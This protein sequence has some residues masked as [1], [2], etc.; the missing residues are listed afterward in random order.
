MLQD[1]PE[2]L[3]EPEA[4]AVGS[5]F[6]YDDLGAAAGIVDKITVMH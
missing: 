2:N 4:G 1:P 6:E 5:V 3:R